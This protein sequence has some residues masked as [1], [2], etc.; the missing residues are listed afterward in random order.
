LTSSEPLVDAH[1]HVWEREAL[2]S[3]DELGPAGTLERLLATFDENGVSHGVVVQP[4]VYGADH[5]YLLHAL[6]AARDR[7]AGIALAEPDD[8]RGL[9]VLAQVAAEPAIRGIRVPLIRAPAGWLETVGETIWR[10]ARG[11]ACAV[12]A[13]AAPEQL[14]ELVPWLERFGDVPVVVD[15]LA[16]LDLAP[17]G[18]RTDALAALTDLAR[19]DNVSV[20]VSALAALSRAEFP[21]RDVWP[22]VAAVLD[23]FGADRVLWGSDYPSILPY[24]RYPQTV[25]AA[26]MALADAPAEAAAAIFAGNALR[27]FWRADA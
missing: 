6:A 21:H 8:P 17:D 1:V 7:L 11:T 16:R 24:S 10:T 13:F 23:A 22:E 15:H 27:L 26:R 5:R 20:K 3:D 9:D 4:S 25:T 2:A 19:Y 14:R 12:C 18:G